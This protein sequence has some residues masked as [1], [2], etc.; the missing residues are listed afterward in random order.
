VERGSV[1]VVLLKGVILYPPFRITW[2][3]WVKLGNYG[4]RGTPTGESQTSLPKEYNNFASIFSIL[5]P[6]SVQETGSL[7]VKLNVTGV[8]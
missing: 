3:V 6:L 5:R 1:T 7:N 4:L 2:A 8:T